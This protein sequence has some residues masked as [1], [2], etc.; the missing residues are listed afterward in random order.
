MVLADVWR[1]S[2]ARRDSATSICASRW[3]YP[4]QPTWDNPA[5][6]LLPN[7]AVLS[8]IHYATTSTG[9]GI[10]VPYAGPDCTA[11]AIKTLC[12]KPVLAV[13]GGTNGFRERMVCL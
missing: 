13:L 10:P 4:D 7:A 8:A 12:G 9:T 6:E 11:T 1:V 2:H 5:F 3:K